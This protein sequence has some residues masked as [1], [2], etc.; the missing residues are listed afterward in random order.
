MPQNH[1]PPL[2]PNFLADTPVEDLDATKRRLISVLEYTAALHQVGQRVISDITGNREAAFFE[3]DIVDLEGVKFAP[4]QGVWLSV[5]RLR[6]IPPPEPPDFFDDWV[7]IDARLS[8]ESE[9]ALPPSK[10]VRLR[11]EDIDELIS[12]EIID[13]TSDLRDVPEADI[14]KGADPD[15]KDVYL[16]T[17]KMPE[18][19]RE[20]R[21][22]LEGPLRTWAASERPRRKSIAIYN[23]LFKID[24]QTRYGDVSKDLV[25]GV[26]VMRWKPPGTQDG[27]AQDGVI[28]AV[29][30]RVNAPVIEQLVEI[31]LDENDG[32]LSILPR[33][34]KPQVNLSALSGLGIENFQRHQNEIARAFNNAQTDP[35][36]VFDPARA[37]SYSPT[38]KACAARMHPTGTYIPDEVEAGI[39]PE[40]MRRRLPEFNDRLQIADCWVLFTRKRNAGREVADIHRLI[41]KL[42]DVEKAEDLPPAGIRAVNPPDGSLTIAADQMLDLGNS[43]V[44][45]LETGRGPGMGRAPGVGGAGTGGGLGEA[46]PAPTDE[47]TFQRAEKPIFFPKSYNEEQVRIVRR[48]EE[49]SGVLVQGPPGTGKTHTICNIV[50]HYLATGRRVLV[51]ARSPEALAAVRERMPDELRDMVI[52]IIRTDAEGRH[53]LQKAMNLLASRA[54]SIDIAANTREIQD[55][56]A[57]II[58]FAREIRSIDAELFEY[59]KQNLAKR[60]F[61]GREVLP[62]ELAKIIAAEAPRHAWFPDALD[63]APRAGSENPS[64][65]IPPAEMTELLE[66]RRQLGADIL[67]DPDNLLSADAMPKMPEILAAQ[68]GLKRIG[69]LARTDDGRDLPV[70]NVGAIPDLAKIRELGLDNLLPEG[71]TAETT[72]LPARVMATIIGELAALRAAAAGSKWFETVWQ[73]ALGARRLDPA[74]NDVFTRLRE[75]WRKLAEIGASLLLHGIQMPEPIDPALAKAI[76]DLGEGRRPFGLLGGLLASK[77][78][79]MLATVR[80][81]GSAP[82]TAEAWKSVGRFIDWRSRVESFKARAR[83]QWPTLGDPMLVLAA[84]DLDPYFDTDAAFVAAGRQID[85]LLRAAPVIEPLRKVL[86]KMFPVRIDIRAMIDCGDCALAI[87]TI[88]KNLESLDLVEARRLRDDLISH[89]A[90][91]VTPVHAALDEFAKQLGKAK[92]GSR[93]LADA[94]EQLLAEIRRVDTL[95][96]AL[97]RRLDLIDRIRQAGAT[98]WADQLARPFSEEYD[99]ELA[100]V[101]W[102]ET[103]EWVHANIF[104]RSIAGMERAKALAERRAEC[105]RRLQKTYMDVIQAR[106]YRGLKQ[107]MTARVEAALTQFI[108]AMQQLGADTGKGLRAAAQ[109]RILEKAAAEIVDAIPCWVMPEKR[110]CEQLPS[111]L[112]MFDLVIVDEASQSDIT[113]LPILLR[114]K[115][116]LVVGDNQQVTPTPIGIDQR[117][118]Q[119]LR[120]RFLGDVH[121][122]EQMDPATS[123]YDLTGMLYPGRALMLREHFRC[124]HPIIAFSSRFY[125]NMLVPLRHPPASE[126][127]EPPLID[128]YVP[129]GR[130]DGDENEAEAEVIVDAIESLVADPDYAGRTIGVITLIGDTQA[131]TINEMLLERIGAEAMERHKIMCGK[132]STFQGQERHIVFLSMVACPETVRATTANMFRQRFNVAMSRAQDRLVLVRSVTLAHLKEADLKRAVIEHFARPLKDARIGMPTDILDLCESEFEREFGAEMLA[133]GYR[134]RPQ[135]E[136]GAYRI[137][138]VIEGAADARLAIELDGDAYHG[139]DR[140]LEDYNRQKALERVGWKFWRCWGSAWTR[141]REACLADLFER[142]QALGIEPLRSEPYEA[143]Y[144]EHLIVRAP[145]EPPVSIHDPVPVVEVEEEEAP[146]SEATPSEPPADEIDS[147]PEAPETPKWRGA[148]VG[149]L[150]IFHY[151]EANPRRSIRLRINQAGMPVQSGFV[152]ADHPLGAALVGAMPDDEIELASV[153]GVKMIVVESIERADDVQ[154]VPAA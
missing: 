127:L 11:I 93:Q 39:L 139:P 86:D 27:G 131:A 153:E 104:L 133:R 37:H 109:R 24:Q 13:P 53:N 14:R 62:V 103:W 85:R 28:R 137:D 60:S 134:L 126:R 65:P 106:T 4:A 31:E 63:H 69:S 83:V 3:E 97:R 102:P 18:F 30:E 40:T 98:N 120:E 72:G 79:A 42:R 16:Q 94:W 25:F 6:E 149:D 59:A 71:M 146:A 7:H 34:L 9:P 140:W 81:E 117:E 110:V 124:V 101:H 2:S 1:S 51:T 90:G 111:Q 95:R 80:F 55:L 108:T 56:D 76:G 135:V 58:E 84:S 88:D 121:F 123:L 75:D 17:S 12:L 52:A 147:G 154:N 148:S 87:E 77:N 132:S 115:K 44:G 57:R 129:H 68:E 142:L 105:E 82:T 22:Y 70:L 130:K 118:L 138:F 50:A 19:A 151:A 152:A 20:W 33:N 92:L 128:I 8:P 125:D 113:A 36:A 78:K 107:R 67:Y 143:I 119:Q 49:S 26:G 116:I 122:G 21:Q 43:T 10:W 74:K 141:D 29:G 73:V 15:T 5:K 23:A 100:P 136:V 61:R 38:L 114:A 112:G 54:R 32:T 48:L 150:V 41:D 35:A 96:P 64:L 47:G 45:G 89:A 46:R 66:L 144:T 91:G 145:G 99:S